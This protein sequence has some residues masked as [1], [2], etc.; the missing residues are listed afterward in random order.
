MIMGRDYSGEVSALIVSTLLKRGAR[1]ISQ[2]GYLSERSR[3]FNLSVTCDL[4]EANGTPDDLVIQLRGIKHVTHVEGVSLKNQMFDGFLFPLVL[5]DT[6]RVVAINSELMFD[7]QEKLKTQGEKS[8]LVEAGRDYGREVVNRIKQKFEDSKDKVARTESAANITAIQDNVKGY[9]KAAGWGK[10]S[11]ESEESIEQLFIQDP[12]TSSK[13]GSAAG[14]LF[15]HGLVVGMTEAFRNKRFS[16]MEDH[17]DPLT[18]RLTATLIEQGLKSEVPPDETL[19]HTEKTMVL[20]EIEKII[21]SVEGKGVGEAKPTEENEAEEK[22]R[23][24]IIEIPITDFGNVHVTLKRKSSDAE[25]GHTKQTGEYTQS[26]GD[27][28]DAKGGNNQNE[29][30]PPSPPKQGVEQQ[31]NKVKVEAVLEAPENNVIMSNSI[32]IK[33]SRPEVNPAFDL[34]HSNVTTSP[35]GKEEYCQTKLK[36]TKIAKKLW[37]RIRWSRLARRQ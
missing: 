16:F 24:K 8:S 12:P 6:N 27:L 32:R 18:R 19:S 13:G 31:Q 26:T 2:T 25:S 21:N 11:W 1:I 23:E 34:S 14:N 17:Y 30:A 7:I 10:F 5:M 4:V 20:G 35:L 29:V 3:E 33:E 28:P 36:R 22:L 9:M 37:R 15:L